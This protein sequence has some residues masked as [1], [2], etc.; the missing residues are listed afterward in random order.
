MK[1]S[2][3]FLQP[4]LHLLQVRCQA[5]HFFLGACV[6]AFFVR[7]LIHQFRQCCKRSKRQPVF[8]SPDLRFNL[9]Q[10][11]SPLVTCYTSRSSPCSIFKITFPSASSLRA[12]FKISCWASVTSRVR[13]GPSTSMSSLS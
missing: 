11:F 6:L 5:G 3:A 1:A 2:L 12:R 4:L 10:H 9:L 13:T 8:H 7:R